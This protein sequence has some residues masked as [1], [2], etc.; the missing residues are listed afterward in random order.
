MFEVHFCLACNHCGF[1]REFDDE[2]VARDFYETVKPFS[3]YLFFGELPINK[4]VGYYP[5]PD[6]A[7][8]W[9]G[10]FGEWGRSH[11]LIDA[12]HEAIDRFN[13]RWSA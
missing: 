3:S 12:Y 2:T 8:E 7:H 9:R 5:N 4:G 10:C 6:I 11:R 13:D 1:V